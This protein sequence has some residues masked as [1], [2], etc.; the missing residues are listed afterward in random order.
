M[1]PRGGRSP[2]PPPARRRP[3][4]ARALS[5]RKAA[6]RAQRWR[7][8]RGRPPAPRAAQSAPVVSLLPL[9]GA[10]ALVTR[11]GRKSARGLGLPSPPNLLL[12]RSALRRGQSS[13]EI[14]PTRVWKHTV[15]PPHRPRKGPSRSHDAALGSPATCSRLA[16][17]AP[18][19]LHCCK[20]AGQDAAPARP[21]ATPAVEQAGWVSGCPGGG[22]S[23]VAG[24]GASRSRGNLNITVQA[25]RLSGTW[26]GREAA[27]VD[28]GPSAVGLPTKRGRRRRARQGSRA[29]CTHAP[30]SFVTA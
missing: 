1:G 16:A 25:R 11:G 20:P 4:E 14:T 10:Q 24:R 27:F 19:L 5:S 12:R 15:S 3:R 28:L 6:A 17:A 9:G 2:Q 13:V 22:G 26:L 8:Q 21:G 7:A 18:R 29:W 23:S 30:R